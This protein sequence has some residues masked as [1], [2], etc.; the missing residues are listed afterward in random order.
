MHP[1]RVELLPRKRLFRKSRGR[2]GNLSK[3]KDSQSFYKRKE[4]LVNMESLRNPVVSLK[5]IEEAA[6]RIR[7]Y[8]CNTPIYQSFSEENT[9]FKLEC[10][11][12]TRAF[13]IRGAANRMLLLPE[14]QKQRGVVTASSG[15]HGV[16]VAYVAKRLGISAT[17]VLP[18]TAIPE[19]IQMIKSLGAQTVFFGTQGDERTVKAKQ[20]Q[21]EEGKTLISS[22]NEPEIIA[23]QGTC[24]L[25]IIKTMPEIEAV[26]VP[27]GGGGL[28]SGV[29]IAVKSNKNTSGVKV[30][31][32][33]PEGAASMYNSWKKGEICGL[34]KTNTIADGTSIRIPGNLTFP[35]V[36]RFVDDIILVSDSEI[37]SA[38]KQLIRS[39]H[40]LAE[41]SGAE[42]FAG[43]L[44][45]RKSREIGNSVAIVSGGNISWDIL[46]KL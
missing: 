6:Q 45:Y 27:I 41:P 46:S 4:I 7:G 44:R 12:P 17:V 39:E 9:F 15:N 36:Q 29:S 26:F 21:D 20:I 37:L 22:F 38:T 23:G 3:T 34:D 40:V 43:L 33:Q 31:G 10:F 1:R 35:I 11:Q 2:T 8:S 32:V 24:G 19:K 13:K 16:A 14:E 30:I 28:I 18:T 5:D 25:E 42:A